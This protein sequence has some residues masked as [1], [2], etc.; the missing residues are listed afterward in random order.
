MWSSLSS[1]PRLGHIQQSAF[2]DFGAAFLNLAGI[3]GGVLGIVSPALPDDPDSPSTSPSEMAEASLEYLA[4]GLPKLSAVGLPMLH[5][6]RCCD[7]CRQISPGT[8][9]G[10]HFPTG[11]EHVS[12][13]G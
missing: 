6:H 2:E 10:T 7:S 13:H 9:I 4:L 3:C 1:P 12:I 8:T 11:N 5:C